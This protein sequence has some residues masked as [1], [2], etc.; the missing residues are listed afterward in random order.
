MPWHLELMTFGEIDE[1]LGQMEEVVK[2][3]QN[4]EKTQAVNA[5][6]RDQRKRVNLPDPPVFKHRR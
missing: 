1:Y 4:A 6:R 3:N 2:A 5:Q